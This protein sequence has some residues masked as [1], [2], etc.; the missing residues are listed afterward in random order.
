MKKKILFVCMLLAFACILCISAMAQD[1]T[2]YYLY[3]DGTALPEG[4][5]NISV[6]ELY[7]QSETE[8]G[9]FAN[10]KD[11]DNIVIELKE[12]ISYTPTYGIINNVP[13]QS[14]GNCLRIS[15]AATVTVKFN[16]YSWWFT[17]DTG[18]DAFV[19][20][21]ENATLNLIG[22]KAKNPD[23]TIKELGTNYKGSEINENI[24]VYS[25]FVIV[26]IAG[27]KLH[28]ENL[29]A[30][31][32]EESIYQKEG[33]L[34]GKAELE[35]VDCSIL[36]NS[37]RMYTVSLIGKDYSNNNIRIDGGLYGSMCLHNIL[38]NS[39]IK[40]ATVKLTA[41]DNALYL[42]SWK[43]RNVY[44]FP[45]E[46]SVIGGR[47][48]GEGDANII[49][50]KNS[51]FGALYLKGDKTGGAFIE[52]IDS[53]YTSVDF[54]EK[55]GQL[56]VYTSAD[57]EKAGTKTVY[58][59]NNTSGVL[60][61]SYNA[62]AT[63][64]KFDAT[65]ITGISYKKSYLENGFYISACAVCDAENIAE[66]T[67]SAPALFSCLGYSAPMSGE[68]GIAIGFTINN[69][70]VAEYEEITGKSIT[71]GVY[72]VAQQKLGEND[73]FDENGNATAGV[74]NADLTSYSVDAFEI[75]IVGFNDTQKDIML[76]LGGYVCV[77]ENDKTT[78]SYMQYGTPAQGQ[79]YR[80]DSYNTVLEILNNAQ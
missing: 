7:N 5:N 36:T 49:V 44:N 34:S 56:T 62:P 8:K 43:D 33:Y 63:G 51:S 71:F 77:T 57:C 67:A 31:C 64:H 48:W 28:C 61:E 18:Y 40:N 65:K 21:N 32:T 19:V 26:Y 4:E 59:K 54:V 46:N 6:T 12:S 16:G 2:T 9:L 30:F 74:I 27:G 53:T 35:L 47:Y 10:L 69:E 22:T 75:K 73:I 24:D 38:D 76:A 13:N 29:A 20:Y 66:E 58:D 52:L 15:V 39:Y 68:A 70:A 11:G 25:D 78:Y 80:F 3:D 1:A 45:I 41:A 55:S 79:N 60:D 17:H 37:N 42:D 72:A 14:N 50:G 23:G